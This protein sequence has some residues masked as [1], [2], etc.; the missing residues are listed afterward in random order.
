MINIKKIPYKQNGNQSWTET[1]IINSFCNWLNFFSIS[2]ATILCQ[3]F[4]IPKKSN[5]KL[6]KKLI[7]KFGM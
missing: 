6:K 3:H 1:G 5:L 7:I 2:I 4:L